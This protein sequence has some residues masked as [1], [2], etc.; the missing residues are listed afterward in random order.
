MGVSVLLP[1]EKHPLVETSQMSLTVVEWTLV[2]L[3]ATVVAAVTEELLF[4]GI[5]QPWFQHRPSGP[6]L[7]MLLTLI[8]AVGLRDKDLAAAW[9]AQEMDERL[10]ALGRGLAPAAFVILMIPGFLF[11]PSSCG[12]DSGRKCARAVM[13]PRSSSP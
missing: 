1:A 7:A 12:V 3:V 9:S 5:L 11:S 8:V 2:F 6:L 4:R 13:P 10:Q